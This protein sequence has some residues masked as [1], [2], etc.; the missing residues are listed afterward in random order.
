M[1]QKPNNPL[2]KLYMLI[3]LNMIVFCAVMYM[4]ILHIDNSA[5]SRATT[6]SASSMVVHQDCIFCNIVAGKAP[7]TIVGES[8]RVMAFKNIRPRAPIHYLIIPKSH[9]CDMREI[10][11][12]HI[13]GEMWEMVRSLALK[14]E[15]PQAFNIVVN[16]GAVAGQSVFHTHWHF[17]S[18]KSLYSAGVRL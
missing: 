15:E 3:I 2:K 4:V 16:N 14:L 5:K 17:V 9:S 11:D 13:R 7:S 1:H 18:G 8:E 12:P 10:T 6:T